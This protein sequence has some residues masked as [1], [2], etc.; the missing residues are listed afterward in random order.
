MMLDLCSSAMVL[1][2]AIKIFQ[3]SRRVDRQ[4]LLEQFEGQSND[5]N[6]MKDLASR[7]IVLAELRLALQSLG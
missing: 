1:Q 6:A 7:F 5:N 4:R 2:S 3:R